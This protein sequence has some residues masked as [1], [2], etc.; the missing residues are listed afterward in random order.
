MPALISLGASVLLRCGSKKRELALDEFYLGYQ[1]KDL[2][3]GEFVEALRLPLPDASQH[4][5]SYKISKRFDQDISA[6]CSA[7][8]LGLNKGKVE[9]I[10]ICYGGMA[11]IPMRARKCELALLNKPWNLAYI[12][13]AIAALA[14][15]FTP[16]SDMRASAE[17]RSRIAGNLLLRFFHEV[18]GANEA[19]TQVL[20]YAV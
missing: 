16:L 1:Q 19:S 12:E 9:K 5:R 2:K 11:A 4:F 3:K 7:Y 15:D 6:V 20:R 14:E 10:G 8:S 18:N 17:Y 13:H